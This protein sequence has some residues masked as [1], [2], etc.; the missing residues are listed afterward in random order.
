MPSESLPNKRKLN[1]EEIELLE[2]QG[3]HADIRNKLG[4]VTNLIKMVEMLDKNPE[5]I[6]KLKELL[7]IEIKVAK[8]NIEHIILAL[9][10]DQNKNK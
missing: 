3:L 1:A 4:S 8:Q 9:E 5:Q 6:E 2:H 10:Y 7:K